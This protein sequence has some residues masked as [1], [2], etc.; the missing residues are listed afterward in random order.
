MQEEQEALVDAA[1][2]FFAALAESQIDYRLGVI[3][4]DGETLRGGSFTTSIDAFRER[5]QVGINGEGNEAGLEYALRA[6][7]RA[8]PLP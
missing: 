6:I 8:R 1:E 3:T 5:V 7:N 4:T 2:T